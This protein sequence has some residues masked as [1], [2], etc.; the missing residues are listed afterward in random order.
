[1]APAS[2]SEVGPCE[3]R[4]T[5]QARDD[6]LFGG[7]ASPLTT[8]Q[9][10]SSEIKQTPVDATILAQTDHC[11]IQAFRW[12]PHAYGM[13]FHAEIT[14]TTVAEWGDI[15]A[16]ARS[17]EDVF[18]AGA[19]GQLAARTESLLPGFR[20]TA[21]HLSDRFLALVQTFRASAPA[22]SVRRSA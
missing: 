17:L 8:F 18:G 3:V 11:K 20:R 13:Q 1:M 22:R 19:I 5:E 4:L 7:L 16:Y 14:E 2:V 9:W 6:A 12:G 10:H 15:P 21:A